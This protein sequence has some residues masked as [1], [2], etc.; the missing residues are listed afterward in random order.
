VGRE[1]QVT[2]VKALLEDNRLVTLTGAGGV[3]KTR[4][5][6]EVADQLT[7]TFEDGTWFV[8]LAPLSD[9]E[10]IAQAIASVLQVREEG[11]GAVFDKIAGYLESL[12][13]LLVLDN[14]EHLLAGC[15]RIGEQLLL[16]CSRLRIL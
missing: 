6:C 15:S 12:S 8:D 14:C 10:L 5:A 7:E 2:Q 3:G 13:A 16:S 9:P 4:L 1:R 11:G